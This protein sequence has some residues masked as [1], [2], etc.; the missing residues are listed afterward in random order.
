MT[1]NQ[2]KAIFEHEIFVKFATEMSWPTSPNFIQATE[3]PAPDILY[4]GLEP[5]MAFE[6]VEICAS[7]IAAESAKLRRNGGHFVIWTS[8]PTE[9][10][11]KSKLEKS[12]V[13]THPI[14]LLCYMNGRVVTPDSDVKGQITSILGNTT[15]NKF[16]QIWYFGEREIFEFSSLGKLLSTLTL[17]SATSKD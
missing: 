6:L 11:L 10:I 12:Y 2:N 14:H 5:P 1:K 8:D 9:E 3:P 16:A 7:D 17:R 4:T 13:S 15:S